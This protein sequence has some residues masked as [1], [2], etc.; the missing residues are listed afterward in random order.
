MQA[1]YVVELLYPGTQYNGHRTTCI[2]H[3]TSYHFIWKNFL[4]ASSNMWLQYGS[5]PPH[6]IG[7]KVL[8]SM[9]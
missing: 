8:E 9:L 1:L 5:I 4:Q 6:F 2:S 3:T 7:H